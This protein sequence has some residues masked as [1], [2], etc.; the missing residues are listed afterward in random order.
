LMA[1]A[2]VADIG[3]IVCEYWD[4]TSWSDVHTMS[5]ES[6]GAYLPYAGALFVRTGSEQIRYDNGLV[7]DGWSK[8]DPIVPA[9]G[10]DRYWVRYRLTTGIT[11]APIFQQFKLHT[12]RYEIN[13]D[14]FSEYFGSARPRASLGWSV[15]DI[16]PAAS[17]ISNADIWYSDNLD[18]GME[19]NNMTSGDRVSFHDAMPADMDT[20]TPVKFRV[21]FHASSTGTYNYTIRWTF[22]NP[23]S[24]V[25]LSN[26][27]PATHPNEKSIVGSVSATAGEIIWIEEDIEYSGAIGRRDGGFGDILVVGLEANTIPGNMVLMVVDGKY[28]KWNEGEHV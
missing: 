11:T 1:T 22:A 7:T 19:E 18:V 12:N 6:G 4:G 10:T 16:R 9:T 27:A 15:A 3:D 28:T 13:A 2:A 26:V 24:T 25:Y 20:S 14:G 21:A 8:N 23:N 5:T 17:A